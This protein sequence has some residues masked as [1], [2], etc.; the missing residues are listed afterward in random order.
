MGN[1]NHAARGINWKHP[2]IAWTMA[3][4]LPVK[5]H[6]LRSKIHRGKLRRPEKESGSDTFPLYCKISFNEE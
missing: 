3:V 4:D 5:S 6:S 1:S 2:L